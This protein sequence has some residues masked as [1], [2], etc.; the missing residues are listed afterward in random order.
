MLPKKGN[1]FLTQAQYA[2]GIAQALKTELGST[3]QAVKILMRWTHASEKT[4]KNWLAGESGPRGE[5]LAALIQHSD[6]AL[7][8]FLA[9]AKRRPATVLFAL[10][11]VRTNLLEIVAMIDTCLAE[12]ENLQDDASPSPPLRP[13]P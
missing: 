3:H 2:K 7:N 9:M 10:P 5:H 11:S 6:L 13:A 4:A 1:V 12:T 8:A